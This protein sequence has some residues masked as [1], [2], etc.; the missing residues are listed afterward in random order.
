MQGTVNLVISAGGI[1]IQGIVTRIEEGAVPPLEI[2]IARAKVG[3]LSTRTTDTSGTLTL[4][5]SHGIVDSDKIDIG[6]VD[7]NGDFQVAYGA[8]VGVVAAL[9]VPFTAAAGT[10]L[11]TVD[12]AITTQVRQVPNCDFDGDDVLLL[13]FMSTRVAHVVFE[14]SANAVLSAQK[15]LAS[16]PA[17]YWNNGFMANPITGNPC[18][19]LQL[20]NLDGVDTAMFK[21]CGIINPTP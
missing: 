15:L 2:A 4:E 10:V 9:D 7:A 14:D 20:T 16:E 1:S 18:D 12:Y 21:L 11:P 13:A 5:S 6:W 19:Q 3:T 17:L 8:L